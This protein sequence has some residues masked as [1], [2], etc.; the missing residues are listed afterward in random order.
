MTYIP[1]DDYPSQSLSGEL[2]VG[3]TA[4]GTIEVPGD[5]DMFEFFLRPGTAYQFEVLDAATRGGTLA[6]AKI[7]LL[8]DSY[9]MIAPDNGTKTVSYTIPKNGSTATCYVLV[10]GVS[11]AD[12][13]TYTVRAKTIDP[14]DY[15]TAS[16]AASGALS[17]GGSATGTIEVPGDVDRFRIKLDPKTTYQ[18]EVLDAAAGGGT[19]PDAKIE[20]IQGSSN[21]TTN[22]V[23]DG[24]SDSVTYTTS[25]SQ[26]QPDYYV[27]ISGGVG[28]STGSYTVK[29][30][31][32]AADDYPSTSI[33][34]SGTLIV[35]GSA[36]G[37]IGGSGDLDKFLIDLKPS[38]TYQFEV[39][40]A[41][42]GGGTL[43]DAKI[44]LWSASGTVLAANNGT[45][46]VTFSTGGSVLLQDYFVVISGARGNNAG[47]Y[48]VKAKA[49]A[50]DDYPVVAKTTTNHLAFEGSLSGTIGLPG[51][52]DYFWVDNLA[53]KTTYQFE[54][55]DA[56]T[57]GGTLSGARIELRSESGA[58]LVP[59]NGSGSVTYSTNNPTKFDTFYLHVSGVTGANMGSYTVKARAV[60]ADDYPS[61]SKE[62]SGKLVV[63]GSATGTIGLPGDVD[64][65]LV[66]LEPY[67]SYQFQVL[68][69]GS[70]GGTLSNAKIDLRLGLGGVAVSDNGSDTI[71]FTTG[72]RALMQDTYVII[73]GA[74]GADTG[75]Y[76]VKAVAASAKDK[77]TIAVTGSAH[78]EGNA[79]ENAVSYTVSL[80]T[81]STT[82]TAFTFATKD[83]T[84]IAGTDYVSVD[85]EFVI[86]AGS[87]SLVVKVP[88]IGDFLPE[89]AEY[90]T[91]TISNF[92]GATL[93]GGASS[94]SA[95][96]TILN[97]DFQAAFTLSAYKAL[98]P[99][100]VTVFGGNDAA[101]V[102]HYINN[103]KAEG[104]VSTGFDAEAYAAQNPDLFRY[105]GLDAAALASHY[106]SNGKAE[107]R[108]ADGF[109]AD[110]YAALNPDLFRA[111]G[112][113]HTALI[114]HYI[115]SGKAEGRVATGFDV[116]AYAALNGDLYRFFGLD[117]AK[118]IGHY[119]SNGRAEG[120]L[121]QGF[122]AEAYAAL[123]PDLLTVFG[124]DHNAL[125]NHYIN[126]GRAEGRAAFLAESGISSPVMALVGTPSASPSY[127]LG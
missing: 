72:S 36:T 15:P 41:A 38:T 12:T 103:G 75:S 4:T 25:S 68:D 124:L 93:A 80:S 14:D 112:T 31:A 40:D 105:F 10:S 78:A 8:W 53:P 9:G 6:N 27:V 104:R 19:L 119:I 42:S 63:G 96:G 81:T 35:G 17:V 123:N 13:G 55:L 26:Q 29:A 117:A 110:A 82:P 16:L 39:L 37:I 49:V 122:D 115:N 73:S 92:V 106:R 65:F 85:R 107:G 2:S 113:D 7:E 69:A 51:D 101:Y 97:D 125:I 28:T 20:L 21:A 48:T 59:D 77:P 46:T 18:F 116:E 86:P 126:S 84:A 33:S 118:L 120:R 108:V 90:F 88:I 22:V 89:K 62:T 34:T 58:L 95:T 91:A 24:G 79:H 54:V 50:A 87:S 45:D 127:E 67:T 99:D 32:I 83:G 100:L 111:F 5:T 109:D 43:P 94:S 52:V 47:T 1:P 23:P 56:A 121:A 102:S 61:Y 11:G 44:E 70:G 71:G 60:T 57:G 64:A 3:G 76:T 114:N 98:N 74:S 66:T 30:T